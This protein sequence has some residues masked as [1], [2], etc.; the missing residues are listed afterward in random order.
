MSLRLAVGA[1]FIAR[2]QSRLR[3]SEFVVALSLDRNWFTPDQASRIADRG[4]AKNLLSRD[5]D[6]VVAEIALDELEIPSNFVPDD[7]LLIEPSP[8]DR[9]VNELTAV[10]HEKQEVVAGINELQSELGVTI[11]AAAVVYARRQGLEVAE[12][13]TQAKQVVLDRIWSTN[14]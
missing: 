12:M 10:G 2:G 14:A 7:A 3:E 8:F 11:E 4:V 5:G 1:P 13:A 6:E 9:V